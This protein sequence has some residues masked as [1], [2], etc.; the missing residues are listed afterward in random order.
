[1]DT[2]FK[3]YYDLCDA[4]YESW[5]VYSQTWLTNTKSYYDDSKSVFDDTKK[6]WSYFK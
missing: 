3:T 1:M 6:F 5:K 4:S 2:S